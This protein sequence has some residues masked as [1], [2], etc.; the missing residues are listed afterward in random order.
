MTFTQVTF[1][2]FFPITILCYF[3]IPRRLRAVW[4]L[5]CSY[6]FYFAQAKSSIPYLLLVTVVAYLAG[7]GFERMPVA[8]KS[9]QTEINTESENNFRPEIEHVKRNS[10]SLRRTILGLSILL[11]VGGLGIFKYAPLDKYSLFMPVG[12]SFFTFQALSYIFDTYNGKCTA[13]KD[14]V[15]VALFV[16]FFPTILSGP[17]QRGASLMP[18]LECDYAFD[19]ERVKRG[20][21]TMLWGYFLKIV[22]SGRLTILT[23]QVLGGYMNY[24]GSMLLV[25][26]IAYA[27]LIYCDFAGYSY[28]AIGAGRIMGFDLGINFRQPYLCGSIGEFWRRWHISLSGWFRDYLYIPLGGSRKGTLRKYLNVMIVFA[29]SGI[30]HG[31]TVNFLIWGILNGAYQVAGQILTPFKTAFGKITHLSDHDRLRRILAVIGCFILLDIAWIFFAIP[32]FSDALNVIGRIFTGF[33][34]ADLVNGSVFSLG[35]GVRNLV[36]AAFAIILLIASDIA[37]EVN[38]CDIAGL[39]PKI[40]TIWRWVIYYGLIIMILFSVNL[41]TTE[42]IYSRF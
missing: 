31:N 19:T 17:I 38:D 18:Q 28:I 29:V 9:E 42:F 1:L 3:V 37:C 40:K 36:I 23:T 27:F 20:L 14:F 21:F 11:L 15:K 30:W 41:S 22:I 4:L 6:V 39:L 26:I 7:Y 12:I 10:Q 2:I 13:E 34:F 16:S 32:S 35:L 33:D 24:S 5:L 25:A 8:G